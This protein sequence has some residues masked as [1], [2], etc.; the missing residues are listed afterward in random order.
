M[1]LTFF[2]D[3]GADG[4]E[5][6]FRLDVLP[7]FAE[8]PGVSRVT[9]WRA[10]VVRQPEEVRRSLNLVAG[11][12]TL[13]VSDSGVLASRLLP[14]LRRKRDDGDLPL[15][16]GLVSGNAPEFDLLRDTPFQHLPY[17]TTAVDWKTGSRPS[18]TEPTGEDLFR[19]VY[20]FRYRE[21]VS[22]DEGEDWYLGHHTREG[23]Q[24]PGLVKYLTWRRAQ[25]R[26]LAEFDDLLGLV[27][28]TELCFE[29]FEDWYQACYPQGPRWTMPAAHPSGVWDDY[30]AFFLGPDP[31][32]DRGD[33]AHAPR[34]EAR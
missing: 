32:F 13:E 33:E 27:R 26:L 21:G 1:R 24:L 18:V 31:E 4:A 7:G 29:S 23:K 20:M 25:R 19:Y 12:A 8:V 15:V 16:R 9:W 6:R 22:F 11:M 17:A 2:H 34:S 10:R 28:Y 5:D 3:F 14:E 30:H